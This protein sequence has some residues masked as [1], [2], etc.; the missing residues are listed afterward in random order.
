MRPGEHDSSPGLDLFCHRLE[1]MFD[2]RHEL[3]RL[4][5][6]IDWHEF[7][8]TFGELYCADNGSPAKATRLMVGLQ[9]LKHLYGLSDEAVV[10]R[11]IE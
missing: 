8:A 6:L 4:S 3:F 10:E 11:W 9:Y 2:Q 5:G 7:D 1:H